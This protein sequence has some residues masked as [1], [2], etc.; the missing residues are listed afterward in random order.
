VNDGP[1]GERVTFDLHSVELHFEPETDT[2]TTAPVVIP[3]EAPVTIANRPKLTLN[4]QSVLSLIEDGMPDGRMRHELASRAKD[5]GIGKNRPAA[6][7]DI[8]KALKDK[9][10]A[11]EF[12][13]RWFLSN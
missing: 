7:Y 9:G 8:C 12:N 10:L 11:Y 13:E 5:I 4:Q 6:I 3:A 1:D 2:R